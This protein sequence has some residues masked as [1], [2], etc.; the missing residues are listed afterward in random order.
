MP[1]P[2]TRPPHIEAE[3][4]TLADR[5][6]VFT[7]FGTLIGAAALA[8]LV[9]SVPAAL[10]LASG[11]HAWAALAGVAVLPSVAIVAAMRGARDGLRAFGGEGAGSRAIGF[12]LWL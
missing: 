1:P 10:R 8:S 9:A 2:S 4:P 12:G 7:R 3:P 5:G 6:S 11:V